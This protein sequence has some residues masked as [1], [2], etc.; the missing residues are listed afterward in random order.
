MI[1]WGGYSY[2]NTGGRYDP[3][4]DSWLPTTTINVPAARV[5]HSSVWTGTEMIIWGGGQ[6]RSDSTW[7]YFDTGGIY[8]P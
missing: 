4:S 2:N 8:V 5:Y 3:A 7:D 1:V 6:F